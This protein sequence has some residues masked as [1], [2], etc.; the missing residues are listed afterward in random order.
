M[1]DVK[2]T[3]LS[4]IIEGIIYHVVTEIVNELKKIEQ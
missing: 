3:S 4:I 1:Q 2:I